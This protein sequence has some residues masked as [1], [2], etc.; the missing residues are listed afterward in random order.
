LVWGRKEK[1]FGKNNSENQENYLNINM[2]F[3]EIDCENR[4]W[5][6]LAGFGL[7]FLVFLFVDNYPVQGTQFRVRTAMPSYV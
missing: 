7:D 4:K 3:K 2:D 6:E 5:M 1:P